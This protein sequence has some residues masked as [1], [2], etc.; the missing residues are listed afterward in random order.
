MLRRFNNYQRNIPLISSFYCS[1][2]RSNNNISANT[3]ASSSCQILRRAALEQLHKEIERDVEEKT[4]ANLPIPPSGW[5]VVHTP[6]T[7]T[8]QMSTISHLFVKNSSDQDGNIFG[9]RTSPPSSSTK[10]TSMKNNNSQPRFSVKIDVFCRFET[11]DPSF[12][13]PS[14]SICEYVPFRIVMERVEMEKKTQNKRRQGDEYDDDDDNFFSPTT[15]SNVLNQ[16]SRFHP[17]HSS[18]LV[19]DC[20][21]VQSQLRI[22]RLFFAPV[23]DRLALMD[24]VSI[25]MAHGIYAGPEISTR[26]PSTG[27][28]A[29]TTFVTRAAAS[30]SSS[31]N[32]ATDS[33]SYKENFVQMQKS[34]KQLQFDAA[35]N[36]KLI[37]KELHVSIMEMLS[38]VGVDNR[39]GEFICQM[40][41]CLEH[42]EYELWLAKLADFGGK[43]GGKKV[44]ENNNTATTSPSPDSLEVAAK[45]I[46]RQG[47]HHRNS[48]K[49]DSDDFFEN[50]DDDEVE[51][52]NKF[53]NVSQKMNSV[54][55][56][57]TMTTTSSESKNND[58]DNQSAGPRISSVTGK[59]RKSSTKRK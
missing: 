21:H 51:K 45:N 1:P 34:A 46:L 14:V 59:P 16:S 43:S 42:E 55:N 18:L 41:Y 30:S 40:G 17:L 39:L 38:S 23:A 57:V 36:N 53:K 50:G 27:D 10:S 24:E 3:T 2:K 8:F 29:T 25:G 28:D 58:V 54:L 32:P 4:N 19:V 31:S 44:F 20:A 12:W 11:M 48:S 33:S 5:K 35:R 37:S 9:Y 56:K 26:T 7:C 22:R 6:G 15:N 47:Y 52:E 49:K 13:E